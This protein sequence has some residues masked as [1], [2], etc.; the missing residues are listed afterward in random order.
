LLALAG[1]ITTILLPAFSKLNS[2][3]RSKLKD[4]YKIAN[5]YTSIIIIPI[6]FLI[7]IFSKDLIQII[8]GSTYEHASLFLSTYCLVY[9]LVGIGYIILPSLFNGLGETKTTLKMEL[10]S[11]I[12]LILLAL[13]LT[14]THGVQG[15]IIAFLISK[16]AGTLY[17][18]RKARKK[19]QFMPDFKNIFKIYII[20]TISSV[21]PLF[22][23]NFGKLPNLITVALGS[24]LYLF[25]Y[26]TLLPLTNVITDSELQKTTL[27]TRNIQFLTLLIRPILKYQRKILQLKIKNK[28]IS[29]SL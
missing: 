15:I 6:T 14:Q 17:G 20:S 4:F 1:P 8:Y 21:I 16:T 12:I 5:K 2:T 10:I 9:L 27:V 19:L 29:K 25:S 13:P 18:S 22:L 23:I 3:S 26:I 11:F 24:I 28:K 7:I